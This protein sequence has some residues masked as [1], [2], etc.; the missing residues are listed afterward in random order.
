MP[1]KV[2]TVAQQKGGAGKTTVSAHLGVALAE[3]GWRVS[4]IDIDPQAS[5]TGW[6]SIR[7]AN[8]AIDLD[9]RA[10]AG[11]RLVNEIEPLRARRDIVLIDSPPHAATEAKIA[12]RAADLVVVPVQLS[13]MDLWA[14]RP[15]LE[16][17]VSEKTQ[18]LMVMNRVAPRGSVQDRI[19]EQIAAARLPVAQTFLGN[20]SA[21]AA[22]LMEG[23]GASEFDPTCAAAD[24]IR[25]LASEIEGRLGLRRT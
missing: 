15:T 3:R 16:I 24:E 25:A 21:Y 7:R 8:P 23:Q 11:W 1:G 18:I 6:H 4:L 20:R 22:S 19:R 12:I 17:A 9:C 13:P 5:L 2:I 14:T 10:L